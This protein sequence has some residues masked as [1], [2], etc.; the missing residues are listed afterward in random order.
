[1]DSIRIVPSIGIMATIS[2]Y[3]K[4]ATY[5]ECTDH[6]AGVILRLGGLLRWYLEGSMRRWREGGAD[7]VAYRYPGASEGVRNAR[8]I[9]QARSAFVI[10]GLQSAGARPTDRFNYKLFPGR[11][12]AEITSLRNANANSLRLVSTGVGK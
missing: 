3:E 5:V 10:T 4:G 7:G 12:A 2:L 11:G 1:M 6:P 9:T 8:T